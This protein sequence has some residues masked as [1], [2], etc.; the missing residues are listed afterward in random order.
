MPRR[1]EVPNTYKVPLRQWRKWSSTERFV[2]NAVFSAAI[3]N[4]VV[5]SHPQMESVSARMWRT[6]CWNFAWIAADELCSKRKSEDPFLKAGATVS[7]VTPSG[8]VVRERRV[9]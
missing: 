5:L 9:H 8:K 3:K 2:F 4:Q 6:L 1:S 7:D